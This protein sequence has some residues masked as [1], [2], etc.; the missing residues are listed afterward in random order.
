MKKVLLVAVVLAAVISA[1]PVW[2][3]GGPGPGGP[4][5]PRGMGGFGMSCP[6]MAVMPPQVG[7][8]DRMADALQLTEDQ[9]TKLRTAMTKSDE[10]MRPLSRSAADSSRALR[11]ALMAPEFNAQ[12]V[13]DLAATAE[14]AEAALV[15][16]RIDEWAQIRSILTADQAKQLQGMMTMQRPGPGQRPGGPPPPGAG[17]PPPPGQDQ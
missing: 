7:M 16:A 1:T 14:K 5:G 13:K 9:M 6:A 10:A 4:G 17:G 2:S 15:S 11:D 3:Q 8:L 12:K